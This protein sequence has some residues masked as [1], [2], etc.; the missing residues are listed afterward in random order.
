MDREPRHIQDD[1]K[2]KMM[3]WG[4]SA[5]GTEVRWVVVKNHGHSW[6]GGP[7]GHGVIGSLLLGPSSDSY[8][9]TVEMWDFFKLHAKR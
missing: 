8:D 6:P 2:I 5:N 3:Q 9:T 1:N 4:P 7:V